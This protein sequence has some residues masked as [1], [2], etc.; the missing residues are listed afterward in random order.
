MK[1]EERPITGNA[2]DCLLSALDPDRNRAGEKY[3]LLRR[4]LTALF[5]WRG[6]ALPE[7]LADQALDVAARRLHEGVPIQNVPGYCVGIARMILRK[8]Q[9]VQERNGR[10][11]QELEI[12][13]RSEGPLEED[14]LTHC[15]DRC[16][17]QLA[18]GSRDLI[19]QYYC[20]EQQEKIRARKELADRLG[21][22]LNALRIRAFRIRTKLEAA[23]RECMA[24]L[25]GGKK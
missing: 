24:R 5:R 11:L 20:G 15:F 2:F 6:L 8:N 25:T 17:Q 10:S 19:Y 18:A 13:A 9:H 4:K 21:I 1:T 3:E 23:V 12:A 7:D 14:R 22:P 16:L